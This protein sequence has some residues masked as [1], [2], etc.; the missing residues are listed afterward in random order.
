MFPAQPGSNSVRFDGVISK[1]KK[2]VPGAY[3]LTV[4][5]TAPGGLAAPR[6]LGFT[7]SG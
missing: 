2:L 7:I 4:T 6:T 3:T 1:H 5:A